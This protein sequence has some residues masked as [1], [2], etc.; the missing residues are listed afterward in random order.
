LLAGLVDYKVVVVL[1]GIVQHQV[2]LFQRVLQLQLLLVAVVVVVA[3]LV[4]IRF[5]LP[6]HR[7]AVVAVEVLI[8]PQLQR[9]AGLVA[10]VVV[11]ILLVMQVAQVIRHRQLR[12][13]ETMVEVD[14]HK[15]A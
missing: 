7:L 5:F 8:T 1:E 12:A 6:L 15:V 10:V 4:V 3:A 9:V 11:Q 14:L 13:K 2:L